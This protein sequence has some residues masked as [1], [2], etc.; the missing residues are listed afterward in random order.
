M[1]DFLQFTGLDLDG[2]IL[3]HFG[4]NVDLGLVEK[5]IPFYVALHPF[6]CLTAA[7]LRIPGP[8]VD[9]NFTVDVDSLPLDW[10][11]QRAALSLEGKAKRV[12]AKPDRLFE[13]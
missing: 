8:G 4:S 13:I 9:C 1:D 5:Q 10:N 12:I 2:E 11:E 7:V 3:V 6:P